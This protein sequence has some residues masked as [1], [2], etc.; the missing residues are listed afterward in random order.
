MKQKAFT[1]IELLVVVAIIGLL[2]A[3]GVVAYN[4]Y[5]ASAKVTVSKS[6]HNLALKKVKLLAA[7]CS[8]DSSIKLKKKYEDTNFYNAYCNEPTFVFYVEYLIYDMNNESKWQ[9]PYY[10]D[11]IT[12]RDSSGR[13]K[14]FGAHRWGDCSMAKNDSNV[15]FVFMDASN[16]AKTVS[17]CTCIKT[18]CNQS[19]NRLE[20]TIQVE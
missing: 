7:R 19:A 12:I 8:I 9:N 18:P 20:D 14:K 17:S 15:G 6:S 1:L 4:G 2:A 16:K 5:T 11:G 10:P 3:V 13:N